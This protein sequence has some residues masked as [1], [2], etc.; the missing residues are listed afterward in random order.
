M[1]TNSMGYSFEKV[2]VSDRPVSRQ[3][4]HGARVEAEGTMKSHYQRLITNLKSDFRS[5][6]QI[7]HSSGEK[8]IVRALGEPGRPAAAPLPPVV[9]RV[10]AFQ[11]FT[12]PTPAVR[13]HRYR[14][15]EEG[16][17]AGETAS[18]YGGGL[19]HERLNRRSANIYRCPLETRRQG[20]CNNIMVP[21]FL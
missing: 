10:L 17:K 9:L 2:R 12:P 7:S 6:F 4:D 21:D 19:D 11:R 8:V 13:A 14:G 15:A 3:I 18:H 5:E 16:R 20:V 1:R